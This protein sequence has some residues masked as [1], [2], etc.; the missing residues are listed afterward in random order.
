MEELG[1]LFLK[2]L[3]NKNKKRKDTRL[4]SRITEPRKS[5]GDGSSAGD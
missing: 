1:R 2:S 3:E 5:S 4:T